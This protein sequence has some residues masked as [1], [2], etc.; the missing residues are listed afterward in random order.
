MNNWYT[1][2]VIKGNQKGRE[3]GFPTINL[4]NP[5]LLKGEKEG[6]YLAQVRVRDKNHWGMLYYGPRLVVDE[7]QTTLEIHLFEFNEE[8]YGQQIQ[9]R[10]YDYIRGVL[11]FN[12]FDE[13]KNQLEKDQREAINFIKMVVS[14]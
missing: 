5:S 2:K 13:L 3:I 1:S 6:V 7:T 11:K 4:D 8:L 9:I 10:I 14:A 12:S